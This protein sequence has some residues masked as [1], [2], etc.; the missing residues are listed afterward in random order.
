MASNDMSYFS[1][2]FKGSFVELVTFLQECAADDKY[3]TDFVLVFQKEISQ[4][5]FERLD[6]MF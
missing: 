2:V 6:G 3:Y 1:G 5:D 4:E